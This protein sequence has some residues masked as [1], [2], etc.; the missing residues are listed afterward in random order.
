[1]K[2]EE[3]AGRRSDCPINFAVEIFG[4][5]W[6]LLIMRDI[7]FWGKKTYGEFLKS[8]EGIATNILAARLASLEKEGIITRSPHAADRRKDIYSVTEKGLELIP[9]LIEMVAWSAKNDRWHALQPVGAPEQI[10]LVHRAVNT[11]NKYK[12]LEGFKETVR[13][14]RCLFEGVVRHENR[15]KRVKERKTP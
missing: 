15:R 11:K 1:M 2:G 10:R 14:G 12:A 9:V 3:I 4:D 13:S 6:S 7:I 5:K 8:D